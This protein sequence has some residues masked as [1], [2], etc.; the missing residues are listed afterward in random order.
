MHKNVALVPFSG[1]RRIAG[2]ARTVCAQLLCAL[3]TPM[4]R[5]DEFTGALHI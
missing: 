5:V 2:A 4:S 1:Y 3:S